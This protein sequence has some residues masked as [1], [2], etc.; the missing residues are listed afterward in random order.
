MSVFKQYGELA[1]VIIGFMAL[2]TFSSY[3]LYGM[4]LDVFWAEYTFAAIL[5][6]GMG[7]L[8]TA[9]TFRPGVRRHHILLQSLF[10]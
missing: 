8:Y 2:L 10:N 7:W 1:S 3:Y 4:A 6:L 9:M 5:L